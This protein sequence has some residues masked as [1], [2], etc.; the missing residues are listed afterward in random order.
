MTCWRY[1]YTAGDLVYYSCEEQ[2]AGTQVC[3]IDLLLF[4]NSHTC[5]NGCLWTTHNQGVGM[6]EWPWTEES[7]GAN[8]QWN[9]WI[10]F[11]ELEV[12]KLVQLGFSQP[13]HKKEQ[14]KWL[15]SP[16]EKVLRQVIH[17]C[18]QPSGYTTMNK[19]IHLSGCIVQRLVYISVFSCESNDI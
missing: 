7:A 19:H 2:Q 6:S 11:E 13:F 18:P 14:L 5:S 3:S 16:C 4:H 15:H 10:H 9:Y 8:M 17:L 1:N 12:P